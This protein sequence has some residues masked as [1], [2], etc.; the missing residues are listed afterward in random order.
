MKYFISIITG[1]LLILFVFIYIN[2]NSRDCNLIYKT[3]ALGYKLNT[4]AFCRWRECDGCGYWL[5]F[6]PTDKKNI[7]EIY[8]NDGYE[9]SSSNEYGFWYSKH[10]YG[11]SKTPPGYNNFS[12]Q[13]VTYG[14]DCNYKTIFIK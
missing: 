1:F 5:V 9:F 2:T 3:N 11:K 13:T 6:V 8:I 4:G 10:V 14:E 7:S 12:E